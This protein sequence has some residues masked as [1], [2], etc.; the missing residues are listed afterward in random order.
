MLKNWVYI[1]RKQPCTESKQLLSEDLKAAEHLLILTAQK[2]T[3]SREYNILKESKELPTNNG[4]LSFRHI[5]K[6]NLIKIGGRFSKSHLSYE[7]KHQVLLNK[8]HPLSRILFQHYHEKVH[9]ADREQTLAESREKFWIVKGRGL[10]KKAIK[11]FLYC[12][13]LRT[14]PIPPLMGDLPYDRMEISQPPFY[15]TGIDYF[16]PILTKQSRRTRSTMGKTKRWGALF[17]CLNTGAVLLEI[18]WNLTTDSFMLAL[19]RFCS[20]RG[21]PHI[22]RSDNGKDFVGA[23]SELKTAMKGLDTKRI[24]E[25][26]NNNQTKWLFNPPCSPWMSRTMESMVKVT[27]RALKT[28]IKERTFTDD[29]L[30]TIMTEVELTVNSRPLKNVSDNIDDYEALT[31]DDPITLQLLTT[32]KL[33]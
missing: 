13:R 6:N 12:K 15:N 26:V 24:E 16:G 21:Y 20:R 23:E 19:R 8:D 17:T 30:Y 7:S 29:A 27:K 18:V 9:H 11:D 33:V 14:K 28:I 1:K 31:H 5:V 3:Y 4:L 25:E 32:K 10:L 2:D 22:I